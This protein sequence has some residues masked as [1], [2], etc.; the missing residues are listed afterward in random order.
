MRQAFGIFLLLISAIAIY[1]E[2]TVTSVPTPAFKS[3]EQADF[4][5]AIQ[6]LENTSKLVQS[7]ALPR[8]RLEDAAAKLADAE[9]ALT[10]RRTLYGM[11]SVQDLTP[12]QTE[13]M[14]SAAQ[15]RLDRQKARLAQ[16]RK[17][18]DDGVAAENSLDPLLYGLWAREGAVNLARSQAEL[19]RELVTAA[20]AELEIETAPI[21]SLRAGVVERYDGGGIF[22]PHDLLTIEA[23]FQQKFDRRLPISAQGETNVHRALGFDHRGRVDVALSPDTK[24]GIWLRTF[25][26]VKKIPYYAFRHAVSGKATAAHIHIGP[27]STRL[28]ASTD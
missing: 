1:G 10:L 16:A 22:R 21:G 9:D 13:E 24:E 19:Y 20:H 7:G 17:L 6:E 27:G 4:E 14:V 23:A 26:K 12:E 8:T 3:A 28:R 2:N 11:L 5:D 15:R 25:L 18:V